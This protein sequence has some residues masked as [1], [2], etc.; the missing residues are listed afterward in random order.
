MRNSIVPLFL[1]LSLSLF[2]SCQ[3]DSSYSFTVGDDT[4]LTQVNTTEGDAVDVPINKYSENLPNDVGLS[5]NALSGMT[6]QWAVTLQY[7]VQKNID[8]K[9]IIR[10][11]EN[12]KVIH[13]VQVTRL[14]DSA[15]RSQFSFHARGGEV[16]VSV[17]SKSCDIG[18]K[19]IFEQ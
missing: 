7:N 13:E 2:V 10:F 1:L 4:Y 17:I 6:G 3:K 16:K 15:K 12:G 19:L 14:G 11:E 9:T 18:A 8:P 5:W